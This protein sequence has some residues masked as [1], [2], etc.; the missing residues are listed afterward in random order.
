[1]LL[2]FKT[3][4]DKA[5]GCWA[6]KNIGGVLGAPFEG[7][8]QVNDAEFYIQDLSKGPPPNDD[9]DLQIV[10]LAAVERYGRNVNASILGD[11]WLSYVIPNWVE[12][13]TGKANLRAGLE[14][15]LSGLID[16]TYK[17]SCGC[18]IRSEIWACLA[19]G[20]PQ[21]AARYAYEDAIVDHQGEGMYGEVFCAAIQSAAFTESD[22]FKL[23]DIGLSYIPSESAVARCV[24]KALECY[25]GKV[26]LLEARKRI[27]N[28]APGTFGIQGCKLSE[29]KTQGNEGME[30]GAPGFDAPENVGFTIAGLLY[31]E[32]D[33]GKSIILA[34]KCGED[35]DCTCATLGALL[36]IISGASKLPEKWTKPLDDR[37]V[38]MCIDKTSGGVWVPD[39]VTQ[40]TDRVIRAV[41]GFLGQGLC[42]ILAPEGMTINCLE[43]KDLYCNTAKDYLP[44]INSSGRS[45]ELPVAE[46]TALSPYIT[47]HSFPAFNIMVD[48]NNS[49]F[50]ND[51]DKRTIK[52]TVTNSFTMRQQQWAKISLY[53]PDGIQILSGSSVL[54]PLNNL[55]GSK[56][57]AEFTFSACCFNGAK[58]ELI[59]DVA[60]EGRHST[61][62]VKVVLMKD[63]VAPSACAVK[64]CC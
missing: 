45:E 46:L 26:D 31:G 34:N 41:P 38:T 15:P 51:A 12:Y 37:I 5:M 63:A 16:N 17:D 32:G 52:V 1:M 47:R 27:H 9:L 6:G 48:Y 43:G 59:V 14:P 42:D 25:K 58:L 21:L 24:K 8:R 4:K 61:G 57:E 28:E 22:P 33:F 20:L 55:T 56:A 19:P 36:G 7:R 54:K 23:V 40:L 39:T 44:L 11:Y 13:G 53:A 35:T 50:F 30:I 3:Y 62:Q 49:A 18:F 10:W 60:L 64:G 2:N 29:V